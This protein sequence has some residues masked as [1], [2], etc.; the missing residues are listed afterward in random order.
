[1]IE[2]TVQLLCDGCETAYPA[3]PRV[4]GSAFDIRQAAQADGWTTTGRGANRSDRCKECS[5]AVQATAK[6]SATSTSGVRLTPTQI[7]LLTD[8]AT[9]PQMFID[10]WKVWHRTAEALVSRGLA[11]VVDAHRHHNPYELRITDAGRAEASRLGLVA[12]GSSPSRGG[13]A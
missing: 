7:E 9:N 12:T 10:Q 4:T 11:V 3:D 13:A 6:R 8:L 5:S 2:T 1:M